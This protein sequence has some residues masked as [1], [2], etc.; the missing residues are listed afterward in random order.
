M[1]AKGTWK[2]LERVAGTGWRWRSHKHSSSS[3]AAIGEEG[4]VG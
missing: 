3:R 4:D 2:E 1:G